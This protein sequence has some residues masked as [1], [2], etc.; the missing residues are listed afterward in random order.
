M[1][2]AL[3]A[4]ERPVECVVVGEKS[5]AVKLACFVRPV[6]GE[7]HMMV[8]NAIQA[9]GPSAALLARLPPAAAAEECEPVDDLLGSDSAMVAASVVSVKVWAHLSGIKRQTLAESF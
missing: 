6:G 3:A 7:T 8:A 2:M 5:S 4:P 9:A 1:G